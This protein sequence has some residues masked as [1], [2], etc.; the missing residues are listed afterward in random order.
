MPYPYTDEDAELLDG[1][2]HSMNSISTF[3]T[4]GRDRGLGLTP[5]GMTV[6]NSAIGLGL[7]IGARGTQP[8]RVTRCLIRERRDL[9]QTS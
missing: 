3:F 7:T 1:V 9:L 8:R 2:V 6:V 4:M 5:K